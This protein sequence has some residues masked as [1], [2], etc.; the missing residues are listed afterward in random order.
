MQ[1]I[2]VGA[3]SWPG[4]RLSIF[5]VLVYMRILLTEVN[6]GCFPPMSTSQWFIHSES[7]ADLVDSGVLDQIRSA[8]KLINLLYYMLLAGQRGWLF[9]NLNYRGERA[10]GIW[11]VAMLQ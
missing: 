4:S 2:Y 10:P 8:E 3:L 6:D 9:S 7:C 5:G 1:T 11:S